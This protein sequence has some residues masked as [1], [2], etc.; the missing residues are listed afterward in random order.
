M[1]RQAGTLCVG[2]NLRLTPQPGGKAR[3]LL[4]EDFPDE[5]GGVPVGVSSSLPKAHPHLC[6]LSQDP[7]PDE[8]RN[9]D[10]LSLDCPFEQACPKAAGGRLCPV[11]KSRE[12]DDLGSVQ[13]ISEG[14]GELRVDLGGAKAKKEELTAR[15]EKL[16][17]CLLRLLPASGRLWRPWRGPDLRREGVW[18]TFPELAGSK[19]LK[20]GEEL[21]RRGGKAVSG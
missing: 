6:S 15:M 17:Q 20:G 7:L 16:G 13:R 21:A 4:Q 19:G 10:L 9:S 5:P 2:K 8:A 14:V 18:D 3:P 11:A 12:W 1:G